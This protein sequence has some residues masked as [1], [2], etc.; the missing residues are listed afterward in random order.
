MVPAILNAVV[1]FAATQHGAGYVI[2]YVFGI[3]LI[4][5][6]IPYWLIRRRRNRS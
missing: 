5:I 2:G 3:V 6:G 4:F 1:T